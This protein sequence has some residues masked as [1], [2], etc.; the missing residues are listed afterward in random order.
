[1]EPYHASTILGRMHDPSLPIEVDGEQD[2]EMD[3]ILD[4]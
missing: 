3:D 1:L 2:Y 4:S